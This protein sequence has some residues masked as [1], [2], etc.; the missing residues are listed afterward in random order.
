MGCWAQREKERQA[1]RKD[2]SPLDL[3]ENSNTADAVIRVQFVWIHHNVF[4]C[5][6]VQIHVHAFAPISMPQPDFQPNLK[7]LQDSMSIMYFLF[8][9]QILSSFFLLLKLPNCFTD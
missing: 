6:C 7:P 4:A 5:L 8:C 9:L 2:A 3:C 1:K